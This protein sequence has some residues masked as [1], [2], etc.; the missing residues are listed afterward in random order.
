MKGSD[1]IRRVRSKLKTTNLKSIGINT[2]VYIND[3]LRFY[4]KKLWS[5]YKKIWTSKFIFG[6]WV[7]NCSVKIKISEC[8]PVKVICHIVDLEKLFTDNPLLKNDR[9]ESQFSREIKSVEFYFC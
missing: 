8:F 1:E 3:S 7:S 5:K 6:Y 4:Y 2:S 9:I